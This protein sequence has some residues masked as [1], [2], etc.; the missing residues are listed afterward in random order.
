MCGQ[1]GC[2]RSLLWLC[3][4]P[5]GLT[6]PIIEYALC[7]CVTASRHGQ[8][9]PIVTKSKLLSTNSVSE[10]IMVDVSSRLLFMCL[11]CWELSNR[12]WYLEVPVG[13]V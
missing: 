10:V 9:H 12:L 13:V 5:K 3:R 11:R 2:G 4:H 1:E 8:D 7:V 6:N